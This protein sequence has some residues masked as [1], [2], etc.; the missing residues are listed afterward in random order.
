MGVRRPRHCHRPRRSAV[1]SPRRP[2][3]AASTD[4]G[5]CARRH[6]CCR[7]CRPTPSPGC[8][9]EGVTY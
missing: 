3:S 9:P 5:V 6:H 4:V 1:G 8:A 2:S 7:C